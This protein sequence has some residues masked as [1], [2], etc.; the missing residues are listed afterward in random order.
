MIRIKELEKYFNGH[1]VLDKISLDINDGEI[2]AIVG[3]SGAG[4]STLLRCINALEDYDSGNLMVFKK[5]LKELKQK[6]LAKLRSKIG[7]IFQNFSLLNQKSVFENVALP[8]RIWGF[9]QDEIE[10]KVDEL[11]K[12]VGL[13]DKKNAYPNELSGGQKQRVAIA[14]A[15]TLEPKILLSDEA[16]SALDPN[17]T[18][19][20]LQ[21]LK[22]INQTL[23]VTIVI[24]THEME[25]VKKIAQRAMLLEKG[26]AIG[27]GRVEELFLKPN[28]KMKNFLAEDE[29]LPLKG[30]NIKLYFSKYISNCPIVSQMSR[31][32]NIDLNIVWGKLERLNEEVVGSLVLNIKEDE[33]EEV[34]QYLNRKDNLV[35][36]IIK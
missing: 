4:K 12:L 18:L 21:L 9:P 31:E 23:K 36:E 26:Q 27:V 30:V 11:L 24:V 29:E 6:E 35:W 8:M 10:Q 15:L 33:V 14:R 13:K 16:T 20:I 17:T 2:F 7:M 19:S 28:D 25:V 3:H 22:K 1:K 5:N 34:T 32:L